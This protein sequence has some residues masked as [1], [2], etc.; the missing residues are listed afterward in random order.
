MNQFSKGTEIPVL[1]SLRAF[2]A[3]SVCLYHFVCTTTDYV[4]NKSVLNIFSLGE[5]GVHLFFVISGFII[6]LSM[7]RARYEIKHFFTF[8]WKR[9]LRLEPPYLIS[10]IVASILLLLRLHFYGSTGKGE[11]TGERLFLHIGYLVPFTD[12]HRLW[13]NQ[14]YW[15]LAIEFQYYLAMALLFIPLVRGNLWVRICIYSS[16][17]LLSFVHV[18]AFLPAW[19]PVFGIGILLFLEYI[20]RISTLEFWIAI[21]AMFAIT[22]WRIQFGGILYII[23][24]FVMIYKF[25][26]INTT[27]GNFL[28]HISYSFY[29]FHP[30][31]GGTIINVLSHEYNT[32]FEKIMVFTVGFILTVFGSYIMYLLVEKW[33]RKLSK[34]VVYS[35]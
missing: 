22:F 12:D 3:T 1:E 10:I 15:T 30:L 4:H 19:L 14:V 2:A 33:S 6:P 31:I 29:L 28:G 7:Y 17:I 23:L 9:L 18:N 21:I 13:I 24:G 16:F 5:F 27:I 26:H 35:K 11:L 34:K 20:K 8:L 32:P 25:K